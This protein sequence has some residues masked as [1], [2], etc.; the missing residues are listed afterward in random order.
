MET[1]LYWNEFT[2][3]WWANGVR[4]AVEPELVGYYQVAK[5]GDVRAYHTM[6]WIEKFRPDMAQAYQDY[7]AATFE[8]TKAVVE[9]RDS[10]SIRMEK[11]EATA[12]LWRLIGE[13]Y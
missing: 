5:D 11:E 9:K 1:Y 12:R 13:T 2:G 7:F 4:L 8:V 3:E 10:F 6:Q